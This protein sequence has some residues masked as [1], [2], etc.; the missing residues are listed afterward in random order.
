MK[1]QTVI[2]RTRKTRSGTSCSY[3]IGRQNPTGRTIADGVR[4]AKVSLA[5]ANHYTTDDAKRVYKS[6]NRYGPARNERYDLV[7]L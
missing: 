1:K 5:E 7:T 2:R 3:I 4:W 6:L